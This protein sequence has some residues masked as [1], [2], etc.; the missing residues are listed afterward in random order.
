MAGRSRMSGGK[1]RKTFRNGF[2]RQHGKNR[3]NG[4]FMRGGIRL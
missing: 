3:M 4:Y 1:S 2:D